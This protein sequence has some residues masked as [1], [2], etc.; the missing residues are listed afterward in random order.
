MGRASAV[1]LFSFWEALAGVK[2]FWGGDA[3]RGEWLR[4]GAQV[5]K[6]LRKI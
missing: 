2:C 4:R 5:Y 6:R 1:R 3:L